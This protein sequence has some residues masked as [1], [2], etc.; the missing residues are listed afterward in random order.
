MRNVGDDE[1]IM[2]LSVTPHIL[3]THTFWTED[4]EKMPPRFARSASFDQESD[5][6]VAVG[7]RADEH[8]QSVEGFVAQVEETA[9]TQRELA[10]RTTDEPPLIHR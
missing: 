3:P 6:T 7:D 2:Y 10:R 5:T 4:G 9:E 1:V 8:L